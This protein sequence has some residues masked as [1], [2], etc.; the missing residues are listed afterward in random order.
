ML[1]WIGA[2]IIAAMMSGVT[3]VLLRKANKESDP[4]S[5]A[6][7]FNAF[8][9]AAYVPLLLLEEMSL[10]PEQVPFVLLSAGI[11][12]VINII[13]FYAFKH[14]EIT[15][16]KPI[17]KLNVLFVAALSF[18]V[19]GEQLSALTS[20]L[21]FSSSTVVVE[22]DWSSVGVLVYDDEPDG[23]DCSEPMRKNSATLPKTTKTM[24]PM[25]STAIITLTISHVLL[26]FFGA[27]FLAGFFAAFFFAGIVVT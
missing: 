12:F 2:I 18:L 20:Y 11:W 6:V 10:P 13:T 8:I 15:L 24:S 16:M 9:A 3:N 22:V 23:L 7:Y 1:F 5:V 19:L 14:T 26:F 25:K 21:Q 4:F 17:M 27:A